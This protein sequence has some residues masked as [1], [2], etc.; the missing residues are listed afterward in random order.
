MDRLSIYL[1]LIV[2]ATITGTLVTG[3]LVLGWYS[4]TAIGIAAT[5]GVLATWPASYLIS[6]RIKKTDPDW[7]ETKVERVE[8]AVPDPKA[9]EV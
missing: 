6:R 7:D 3:V 4:W 5:V 9:P 8:G 1:T 2:G